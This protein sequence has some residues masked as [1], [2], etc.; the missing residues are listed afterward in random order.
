MDLY[1]SLINEVRNQRSRKANG[2]IEHWLTTLA[3]GFWGFDKEHA[4]IWHDLEPGSVMVFQATKPNLDYVEKNKKFPD[5]SGFIGLG[6]VSDKSEKNDYRWL[7]ELMDSKRKAF[8]EFKVW[9]YLVHFS[10]TFWFGNT[11]GIDAKKVQD[12]IENGNGEKLDLHT[13]IEMLSRNI[14]SRDQ[15]IKANFGFGAQGTGGVLRAKTDVLADLILSKKSISSSI[16]FGTQKKLD[17]PSKLPIRSDKPWTSLGEKSPSKRKQKLKAKKSSVEVNNVKINYEAA[18]IRNSITGAT[19]EQIALEL[20]KK[21]I[22]EKLGEK[23]VSKLIHASETLGDL[24]G[25]DIQSARMIDGKIVDYFIEV[26]TT[27]GNENDPFYLS[28]GELEFAKINKKFYEI[29]RIHSLNQTE[30]TYKYFR[31]SGSNVLDLEMT[32]VSYR[33]AVIDSFEDDSS[34]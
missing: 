29:L 7:S 2:P 23:H 13:E 28:A 12:L 10:H 9:P 16:V 30:R 17:A 21:F 24:A 4:G 25:Y 1:D 26:K 27:S 6:L 34:D 11:L 19:G 5:I 14:L 15:M 8:G 20:E 31:L 33:V 32:P 18:T 3:T 22:L